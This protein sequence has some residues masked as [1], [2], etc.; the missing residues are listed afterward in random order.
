MRR[1]A[2]DAKEKVLKYTPD[3]TRVVEAARNRLTPWLPLY[4]HNVCYGFFDT[5]TAT[6]SSQL[7][8]GGDAD[9]REF[10][11]RYTRF[12]VEHGY[13]VVPFEGCVVE[14]IQNGEGLMGRGK[15]LVLSVKDIEAY[16]WNEVP[17]RYFERFSPYF[18]ALRAVLPIGMKAVGGVGNGIFETAQDFVPFTELSYLMVDDQEAFSLLFSKIGALFVEIWRRFLTRYAD[19][20]AVCRFGDDL[21][22][23]S[24]TLMQPTILKEHV[25]P[26]YAKIIKSVHESGKPFLL[27]S[28]G[29]IFAVMEEIIATGIDAKHSNE[30]AIAPFSTWV[31]MYGNRI[32]NFGGIDMN[33]LCI[34]DEKTIKS[35]VKDVLRFCEGKPG[36]AI[37][38]GNQIADYVPPE[39][40]EAMISAVS[41]WRQHRE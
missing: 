15:P 36:I 28:C 26:Q 27:H 11:S 25:I 14:L 7:L 31:E 41:D 40:F 37:G 32:G 2:C 13:D 39:G 12:L 24:A 9:K 23:K 21:G 6:K 22:F 19:M 18:E 33:V 3:Y 4:E 10:F 8:E 16:P 1:T 20:Y 38:S 5:V 34:E 30:D 35:Y 29:K 17:N